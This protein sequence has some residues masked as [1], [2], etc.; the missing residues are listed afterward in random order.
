MKK[1]LLV[2]LLF[3]FAN[4]CN[5]R[6]YIKFVE[7]N[8]SEESSEPNLHTSNSGEIY[9]SYISS[10]LNS[11]ESKL[12]Y[13][14]FDFSNDSWGKSNLI[15][16]SSKMFV[17]W[18]DFPKITADE[19]NGISAHYLEMS[20][21]E[22]F[23]YD[24]KVVN[25]KNKGNTWSIPLKLHN[26]STKTEHGFVST[27]N[28]NNRFLSTYLD[29]RQNELSKNDKSIKP[30][31][32]LRGT[33][34]NIDGEILEDQLIDNRVCDCCQTDLA[35]TKNGRSI[36]V[37]R[38]RSINEVRDIYYS[39]KDEN[40]WSI[41]LSI[42]NDNWEIPGCP[43]NGPAISTFNNTSAVVWYTFSNNNNQLKVAFS[44]DIS[45]GFDTPIIVNTNDPIGRVDIEL[46]DQ[47]TA[48]ISY[49][50]IIDGGAYIKLQ[51]ITSDRN[52]NKL[53]VIDESSENRSSGFPVITLDKEKNK[54]IIAWTENKEK[55]KIKTAL[56]DNLFFYK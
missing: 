44:N 48:L 55:F 28:I 53:L 36:V 40:T 56:V 4:S 15:T 32:T 38:D 26:D 11:N 2:S 12:F 5:N 22:K 17:N 18:A 34:Y 1:I 20:S 51:M 46:L 29:G 47:N 16:K 27:I 24:I 14:L 3:I 39:Y 43:V 31:M 25:S 7:I 6:N 8:F 30:Q 9:L 19:L 49:I 21:E 41:P 10:N 50:D 52:Q 23:S 33:S 45:N 13:S 37:Y 42:F 35:I 54:T